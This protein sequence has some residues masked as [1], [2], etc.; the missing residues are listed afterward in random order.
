MINVIL[1][2]GCEKFENVKED[3]HLN[4]PAGFY[5]EIRNSKI[6][7]VEDNIV[8]QQVALGILKKLDLHADV[9]ND[10]E[11]AI[12]LLSNSTYDLVFM[13]IQMPGIDGFTA[14]Q[15]IRDQQS[16]VIQH[17]IPIVAMTAHA[18]N[19]DSDKCFQ[20]GMNGYITKPV[21][22]QEIE[23]NIRKFLLKSS[24]SE[25]S[26]M[27]TDSE[28]RI[29]KVWNKDEFLDHIMYD[30]ELYIEIINIFARKLPEFT[31]KLHKTIIEEKNVTEAK[32]LGHSIKGAAANIGAEILQSISFKIE[33][34]TILDEMNILLSQ[35]IEA[36]NNL[37]I[38]LT[39]NREIG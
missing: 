28:I 32:L 30:Q 34:C 9:A 38:E 17:S 22:F 39:Q 5:A 18:M 13:D 11:E 20:V 37:Q 33:Q 16:K 25:T 8:N 1:G 7:L 29:N 10:G 27:I 26:E 21:S 3:K 6:L 15:I 2:K 24:V 36:A 19:G 23:E 4:Q 12:N 31:E 35:F 14:T